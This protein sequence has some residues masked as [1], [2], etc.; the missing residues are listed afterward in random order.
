MLI[1]F[2]LNGWFLIVDKVNFLLRLDSRDSFLINN[3]DLFSALLHL[4]VHLLQNYQLQCC[5]F[6]SGCYFTAFSG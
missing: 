6:V 2:F 1:F 4:R 5:D 3:L